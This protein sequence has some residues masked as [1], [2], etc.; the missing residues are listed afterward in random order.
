MVGKKSNLIVFVAAVAAIGFLIPNQSQPEEPSSTSAEEIQISESESLTTSAE[1]AKSSP[2]PAAEN[3][4]TPTPTDQATV[5]PATVPNSLME[6]ILQLPVAAEV[7]EG[8]DRDL[9]RHWID[10]DGD[11]CDTRKEVLIS[12]A[13]VPPRIGSNCSLSVG[14]WYSI[15]DGVTISNP[16]DLDIDHFV[17]LNEAWQSGAYSWTSEKR[18]EFAN[19]LEFAKSLI[20]VTASS[21]RSKSDKDPTNWIPS[22]YSYLCEYVTAWVEVKVRWGLSADQPEID[23]LLFYAKECG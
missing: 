8:Y 14:E 7:T 5:K 15:Y 18:K 21:N 10:S 20:A 11:G 12:E 2:V 3:S 16:S 17:P 1:T 22:N 6:L 9:F 19:D 23:S 4:Q 13:I